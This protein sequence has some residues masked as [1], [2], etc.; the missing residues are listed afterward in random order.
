M[1]VT[2]LADVKNNLSSYLKKA[3]KEPI[4]ITRN[5]KIAGVL[6][7]LS[8]DEVEDYLLERSPKFRK[9]LDE[10]RKQ[11]GGVPLDEYRKSRGL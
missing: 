5:G 2:T 1:K 10:A 7:H 8:E 4:F 11:K 3:A 6:E 9:M